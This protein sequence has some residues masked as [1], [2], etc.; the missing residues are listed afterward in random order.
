ML[1]VTGVHLRSQCLYVAHLSKLRSIECHATLLS[2]LLVTLSTSK[3][4]YVY[5]RIVLTFFDDL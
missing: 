2:Q 4:T 3:G 1:V 5:K